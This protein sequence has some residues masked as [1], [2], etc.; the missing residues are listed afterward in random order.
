MNPRIVL[1][2]TG[3]GGVGMAI[4]LKRA[5]FRNLT[6]LERSGGVGGVWWDNRYPGAACDVPSSLYSFSFEPNYDWSRTHGTHAEIRSYLEFCVRKYGLTPHLRFNTSV[7]SATFDEAAHLWRVRTAAGEEL[8]ADIFIS[9]AG[10]FNRPVLPDFPGREDFAGPHFHSTAWDQAFDP[11]GKRVAVIGTGCSA[12]QIV[13]AIVEGVDRL[14]LFQRTPAYVNPNA[15]A[16]YSWFQRL[17]YRLFPFLRRRER[18]AVYDAA[19]DIFKFYRDEEFRLKLEAGFRDFLASQVTDPEKRRKLTPDYALGCRRPISSNTYLRALDRPNVEIET[20][21]IARIEPE[22]VVTTDGVLHAVDAIV[23]A[24]GFAPA[25]YLSTL[26]V[27]GPGGRSLAD[28]WR[29]G[30]EA[31]LGM[32][33]AGFPNFF[34]IY[35]PNSNGP[36]SIVFT[37]ECQI[38]YILQCVRRWA[39]EGL[40]RMEPLADVQARFN[41]EIQAS[42]SGSTLTSACRSYMKTETGKVVTQWPNGSVAY[43]RATEQVNWDDFALK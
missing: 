18:G 15:F 5:G 21:D 16:H 14:I 13:P 30:A 9:A 20:T 34:M 26:R 23:Y 27:T 22:G 31:F 28:D 39:D 43:R 19:E 10:V 29:E 25:K 40:Q 32:T 1:V 8:E 42:L 17:K 4:A 12:A 7:E 11:T 2:G 6:V 37:I 24:T 38:R 33:V 36:P 3:F 35:G 41:A